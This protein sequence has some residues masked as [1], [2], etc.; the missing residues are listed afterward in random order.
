MMTNCGHDAKSVD[1]NQLNI[2]SEYQLSSDGT[3]PLQLSEAIIMN[4][5]MP[6]ER[7]HELAYEYYVNPTT[8][9][10]HCH[11]CVCVYIS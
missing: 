11:L 8:Q 1:L 2:Y 7:W 3:Q 9:C 4:Q 10:A 5:K 6:H